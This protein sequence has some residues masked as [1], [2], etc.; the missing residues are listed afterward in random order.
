VT[1]TRHQKGCLKQI[2]R[3][4]GSRVWIFR[5]RETESDGSRRARKIVVGSVRDLRNESA[6]REALDRLSLN[7]NL[8]LSEGARP[9]E[10]FSELIEHYRRKE[11]ARDKERK[12]YSTKQCYNDYLTNWI[13]PRWVHTI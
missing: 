8:D 7:V 12:S 11:L 2:M 1:R 3:I 6:A 5:W 10:S 9:P 4:G 13:V